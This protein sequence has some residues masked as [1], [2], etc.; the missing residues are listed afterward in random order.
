M[1]PRLQ[2]L[3]T[4][5]QRFAGTPL[6][7]RFMAQ[8][9]ELADKLR[10]FES[11]LPAIG[12]GPAGQ[13]LARTPQEK[14][15][16]APVSRGLAGVG[17]AGSVAMG[18]PSLLDRAKATPDEVSPPIYGP[19]DRVINAPQ[20]VAE[21]GPDYGAMGGPDVLR[22]AMERPAPDYG[23]MGGHDVMQRALAMTARDVPLPPRRPVEMDRPAPVERPVERIPDRRIDY[24]SNARPVVDR[25]EVN[26]GDPDNAADFFRAD[27]AR[28][29]RA[30]GG[31][32]M[33]APPMPMPDMPKP[34]GAGGRDAAINKALEIIHHLIVRRT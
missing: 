33:D 8:A 10:M 14:V 16:L 25:G 27:R 4:M 15:P 13:F 11:R 34:A 29:G 22:G 9:T 20:R 12:R 17:A 23:S 24:Q 1:D 2:Y 28:M 3:M 18:G 19:D 21:A 31:G 6:G 7:Q 30:E 26:W 5:A 32:I